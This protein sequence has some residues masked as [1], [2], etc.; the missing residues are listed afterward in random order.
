M[1]VGRQ[2]EQRKTIQHS[3]ARMVVDRNMS[4]AQEYDIL[5][6]EIDSDG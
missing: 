1:R 4:N 6:I 5:V 2:E 3:I